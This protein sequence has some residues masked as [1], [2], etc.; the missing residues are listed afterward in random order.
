[1]IILRF[2]ITKNFKK[3]WKWKKK[4]K[5]PLHYAAENNAKDIFEQLTSNGADTNVKDINSQKKTL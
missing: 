3:E 1:M 2:E 4:N 5:T